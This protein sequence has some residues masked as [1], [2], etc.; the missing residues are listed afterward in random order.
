[1]ELHRT[2]A[3][4]VQKSAKA[5]RL[6]L[7]ALKVHLGAGSGVS[8]LGEAP[9]ISGVFQPPALLILI[10]D[11]GVKTAAPVCL[12]S[13]GPPGPGRPSSHSPGAPSFF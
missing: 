9:L 7:T 12:G 1:M 5:P 8:W 10:A 13:C 2:V 11:E 4:Q 6:G 3:L